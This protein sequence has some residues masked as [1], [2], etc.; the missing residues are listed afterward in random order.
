MS[1]SQVM[2]TD[3]ELATAWVVNCQR[4]IEHGSESEQAQDTFWAYQ[5]LDQ[6]CVTN[7]D[8]AL[9]I[10]LLIVESRPERRVLDNL[11]AGPL[12]DLLVRNGAHVL[13]R[14]ERLVATHDDFKW[15]IGGVWTERIPVE[16]RSKVDQLVQSA[17]NKRGSGVH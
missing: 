6:L 4:A 3:V 13:P 5:A 16:L 1:R 2:Q 10:I 12:E 14:V 15:L 8:R 7:P 17:P 11:A 9:D